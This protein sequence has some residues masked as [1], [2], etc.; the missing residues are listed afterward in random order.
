[1]STNRERTA[2]STSPANCAV[3]HDTINP[4]GFAFEN[5]DAM[6]A[7]RAK[8][9][10]TPVD[11]SGK[12]TLSGGESVA[13]ADG[14][15]LARQL[16]NSAQV[17]DCYVLRWARYATGIDLRY[18]QRTITELSAGFRDDDRVKELLVKIAGSDVFRYLRMGGAP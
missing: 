17:R 11:A 12:T 18:D 4:V 14:V 10:G 1:M 8:D 13:F 16:G 6:G 15:A 2:A 3:C 7:W 5:Y 9:N